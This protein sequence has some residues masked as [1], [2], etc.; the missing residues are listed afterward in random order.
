MTKLEITGR[1]YKAEFDGWK[2]SETHES[3]GHY[4]ATESTSYWWKGEGVIENR[5]TKQK[6]RFHFTTSTSYGTLEKSLF[7]FE[8][9]GPN[10]KYI[11]RKRPDIVDKRK[12]ADLELKILF[13]KSKK[14]SENSIIPE[15]GAVYLEYEALLDKGIVADED[16]QTRLP[17][18]K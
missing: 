6:Q 10:G 13:E 11:M 8:R 9:N 12:L 4:A 18:E 16:G 2:C 5:R 14:C 17:M 15:I 3:W 1:T 7:V